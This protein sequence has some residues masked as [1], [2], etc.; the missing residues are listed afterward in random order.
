M[1]KGQNKRANEISVY[2]IL[3]LY[4]DN[5]LMQISGIYSQGYPTAID[6]QDEFFTQVCKK[7]QLIFV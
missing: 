7:T 2:A 1:K 4:T 5:I 3:C 6:I